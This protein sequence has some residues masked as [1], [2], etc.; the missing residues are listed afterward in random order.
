MRDEASVERLALL[1]LPRLRSPEGFALNGHNREYERYL[2]SPEWQDRKARYYQRWGRV[3]RACWSTRRVELH[4]LSYEHAFTGQ[5]PDDDLIGLCHQHHQD[6]HTAM[7]SGRFRDLRGATLYVVAR[8][9]Q[10][11]KKIKRLKRW[12]NALRSR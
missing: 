6:A 3:C 2:R 11:A 5:E 4:H 8:T 10:R 9:R 7:D 12:L 1:R